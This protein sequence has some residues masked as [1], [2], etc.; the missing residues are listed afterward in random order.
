VNASWLPDGLYWASAGAAGGYLALFLLSRRPCA[1]RLGR[2]GW[3]TMAVVLLRFGLVLAGY[4]YLGSAM[5]I[6]SV[7]LAVGVVLLGLGMVAMDSYVW[8][9]R[10]KA[11]DLSEQIQAACAGLFLDCEELRPG[12]FLLRSKGETRRLQMVCLGPRMLILLLPRQGRL[13]KVRL[14]VQWLFKQYAGPIPRVTIV[15][16]KE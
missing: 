10:A 5:L 16:R 11:V 2:L 15:L 7:A 6:D 13:G 14:L 12:L 3:L 8:L 9:V 4:P 1:L